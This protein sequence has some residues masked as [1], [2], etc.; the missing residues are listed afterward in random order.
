M[1]SEKHRFSWWMVGVHACGWIDGHVYM[2]VYL[3]WHVRGQYPHHAWKE[4]TYMYTYTHT[5]SLTHTCMSGRVGG[6]VGVQMCTCM[7]YV[8][9]MSCEGPA[10]PPCMEGRHIPC[11]HTHTLSLTHA[12]MHEWED[13]WSGWSGWSEWSGNVYMCVMC[14]VRL[15]EGW[16]V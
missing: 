15:C 16:H 7:S 11:T 14:R 12:H 13:G 4:R 5:C 3:L 2:Y 6:V 10:S 1:L 9:S 8:P